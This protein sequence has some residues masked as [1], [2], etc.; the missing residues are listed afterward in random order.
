MDRIDCQSHLF[1]PE[2]VRLMEQ[3]TADP[4]VYHKDGE[5][6][7]RMGDW[8]RRILP[9]HMSV[10]AKLEAM[11]K[12]GIRLTALSINDPRIKIARIHRDF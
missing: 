2:H 5:R 3:R 10:T 8:H 11:N 12:T 6:Y 7:V 9:N 1:A 4:L